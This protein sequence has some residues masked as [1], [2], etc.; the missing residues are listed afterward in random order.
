ML[1]IY[2]LICLFVYCLNIFEKQP[3]SKVVQATS[4]A[5]LPIQQWQLMNR[6][7]KGIEHAK[8]VVYP[9]EDTQPL[10]KQNDSQ[11]MR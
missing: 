6:K 2:L 8:H 5:N 4:A 7:M 9:K 11:F 10:A 3:K 1:V